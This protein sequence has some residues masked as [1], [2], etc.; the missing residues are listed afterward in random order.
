MNWWHGYTHKRRGRG[1]CAAH[2]YNPQ[3]ERRRRRASLSI[4]AADEI[5]AALAVPHHQYP[6]E[7]FAERRSFNM[8]DDYSCPSNEVFQ[9][10]M[11]NDA[12]LRFIDFEGTYTTESSR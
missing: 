10:L 11:E 6:M 3:H 2:G 8:N 12:G 9:A 7:V 4:E 1:C 5:H